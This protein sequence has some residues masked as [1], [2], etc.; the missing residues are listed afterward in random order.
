MPRTARSAARVYLL[1]AVV[2]LVLVAGWGVACV[3]RNA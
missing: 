1:D 3:M 2:E